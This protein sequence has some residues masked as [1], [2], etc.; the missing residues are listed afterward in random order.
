MDLIRASILGIVQGLTEYLPVSSSA[1]L[2][3]VPKI[4]GWDIPE[5]EAVVFNILVQMGTLVGVVS[6]FAKDLKAIA[7]AMIKDMLA[8]QPFKTADSRMGWYLGVAT[9]PAGV[10]GL[11]VKPYI[12]E[13]FHSTRMI[14]AFLL[15]TAAILCVGE[16]L[17]RGKRTQIRLVDA[18]LIGCA[19]ILA[20]MPGI[21]RSGSTIS[22]G[23]A[24]QLSK[25]AAARFSF[26]MSI[27][28]M[29]GAG[30]LASR[31]LVA[32]PQIL[33]EMLAPILVGALVAGVV[34][35]LVIG[36]FLKFLTEHSLLWFAAYCGLVGITGLA[37]C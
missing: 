9:I 16:L 8:G 31:D 7:H 14:F 26:L 34:G 23:V 1:H 24:L 21:S 19:Q 27:P 15:V 33:H 32:A 6:Y 2:A 12:K 5:N 30:I 11:L 18:I 25:A 22:M 20:L 10:A 13:W 37:L 35:Y 17:A 28:V 29:L 4:L 36:W 3:L